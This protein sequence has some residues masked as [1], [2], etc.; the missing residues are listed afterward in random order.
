M[1]S[2]RTPLHGSARTRGGWSLIE[3]TII[4]IVL[5]ILCAILAPVIGRFVRNAK[6]VRCRE[7]VQAIGCAIWMFSE[8]TGI[9]YF[10]RHGTDP[11][12]GGVCLAVGDGLIPSYGAGG[13]NNWRQQVNLAEV[14][15]LVNHLVENVPGNDASRR[16]RTPLDVG[17]NAEFAWRG[18]YITPPILPDPWG[19]RYAVNAQFMGPGAWTE[20][21]VV[22]SA[23]PNGFVNTKW[24]V[25]GL[26]PGDD[27]ILYTF[28]ANSRP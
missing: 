26:T 6:I 16:Y 17:F 1:N 15:F 28:S 22:Y 3:L 20:D 21:A 2:L 19:N 13:S 24:D 4:L 11:T 27:D 18:P 25:D 14:D 12:Q 7:D 23:G 10:R 8:D 5:S 9:E